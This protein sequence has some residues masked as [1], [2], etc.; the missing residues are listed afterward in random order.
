MFPS[1][2]DLCARPIKPKVGNCNRKKAKEIKGENQM[3]YSF[4]IRR[5]KALVSIY[6]L[7]G[8]CEHKQFS[9]LFFHRF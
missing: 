8:S 2:A 7:K 4:R 5:T 1:K 3:A 9:S 6:V